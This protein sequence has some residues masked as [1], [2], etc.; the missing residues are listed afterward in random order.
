MSLFDCGVSSFLRLSRFVCHDGR[1]NCASTLFLFGCSGREL[2]WEERRDDGWPESALQQYHT[3]HDRFVYAFGQNAL[4][5][6]FFVVLFLSPFSFFNPHA[7]TPL[8]HSLTSPLPCRHSYCLAFSESACFLI[9][10]SSFFS[11]SLPIELMQ[12][13]VATLYSLPLLFQHDIFL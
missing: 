2:G 12:P 4:L 5:N 10:S 7:L 8:R 9:S 6:H 11:I 3:Y 13:P 1:G